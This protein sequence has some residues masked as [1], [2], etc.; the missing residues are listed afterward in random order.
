MVDNKNVENVIYKYKRINKKKISCPWREYE[1][2][3]TEG[4]KMY[5]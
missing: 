3:A 5:P 1:D 2:T 4:Y